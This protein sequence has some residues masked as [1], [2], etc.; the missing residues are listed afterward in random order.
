MKYCFECGRMTWGEPL[1]CNRCGS[2]FDVKLCPRLHI[3]SRIAQVCSQCGSHELSTPQPRVSLW[4]HVFRF[5]VRVVLGALLVW[6]SLAVLVP[7]IGE[8]L[9][10]PEVQAGMVIL[11]L[12]LV[13]LWFL[14]SLLPFWL[15]KMIRRF[16]ERKDRHHE[17]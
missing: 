5:L 6:L 3:N 4:W 17:R 14:W 8:L 11:G 9:K 16:Y 7:V 10:R 13:G 12:L 2:S 15:R 1:F